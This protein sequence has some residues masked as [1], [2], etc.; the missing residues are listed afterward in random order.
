MKLTP[1]FRADHSTDGASIIFQE[2]VPQIMA[3]SAHLIEPPSTPVVGSKRPLPEDEDEKEVEAVV[4]ERPVFKKP[5][6]TKSNGIGIFNPTPTPSPA[7]G[8]K[9]VD[10]VILIE[11][12]AD[13]IIV[14]D[15]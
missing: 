9:E 14:L 1:L 10:G 4:D 11:D 7:K 5:K 12:D 2:P 13:D 3:P 6:I 15:D 8:Y